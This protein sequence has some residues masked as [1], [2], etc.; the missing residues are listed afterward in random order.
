ML[1]MKEWVR[2]WVYCFTES[3]GI[4][5]SGHLG[6]IL[7]FFGYTRREVKSRVVLS[8]GFLRLRTLQLQS[9]TAPSTEHIERTPSA[10]AS[11]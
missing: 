2:K 10:V 4:V 8:F 6:L 11:L 7:M 1:N 9:I 3:D 5:V